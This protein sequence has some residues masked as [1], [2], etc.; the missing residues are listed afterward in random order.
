MTEVHTH[1]GKREGAG[2]K[3]GTTNNGTGYKDCRL[4]ISCTKYQSQKI[5]ALAKG[6]S[7]TV[8]A[9]ILQKLKI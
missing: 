6:Q 4:V 8:S 3:V 1:G 5:K 7:L 9:Y 2:R